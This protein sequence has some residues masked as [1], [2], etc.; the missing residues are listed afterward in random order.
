MDAPALFDLL[1][2][3][4]VIAA[5]KDVDGLA[6]ARAIRALDRPDAGVPLVAMSANA[7]DE[8]VE[9]SLAAGINAHLA[10]P[11]E[12]VRLYAALRELLDGHS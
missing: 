11:I 6:A 8:D 5:V 3:G 7:F 9:K 10:K 1:A 12:P 4:P 2:D